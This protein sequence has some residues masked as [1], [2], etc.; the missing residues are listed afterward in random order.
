MQ[1]PKIFAMF[2]VLPKSI[3]RFYFSYSW[4]L[5]HDVNYL[6]DEEAQIRTTPVIDPTLQHL[7]TDSAPTYK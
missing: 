6:R 1:S 3:Q 7:N 4:N 2:Y 5:L